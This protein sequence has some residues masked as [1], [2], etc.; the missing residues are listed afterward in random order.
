M[1][2]NNSATG[3]KKAKMSLGLIFLTVFID[4]VGFGLIIPILPTY[5]QQLHASDAMVGL[6]IAAYS[7]MQ[8]L[9]M[10]FWGRLSDKVG[11]KPILLISLTASVIGYVLWGFSYSLPMLFLARM[12]AGAGNANIAVAQA[13][14]ADVTTAENRTK[15]MALI[16][17][18]F[19]L[20]FVFGPAIGG[21]AAGLGLQT[22][23]F[24]AAGFSLVDL[25][26]TALIL[27]EPEKRSHAGE[28][29]FGNGNAFIMQTLKDKKLSTS[30]AI[31]FLSTFAFANMEAT[32]VLLTQQYFHFTPQQNSNLFVYVGVL[33]LLVQGGLVRRL[34]KKNIEKRMVSAGCFLTAIG[35]L[36]TPVFHSVVGLCVALA[37]LAVGSGINTPAN[38]SIL[39]KLSPPEKVGGVLGVGQSLSTLGRI[40]GPAVGAAAFG[41]LGAFCPYVIGAVAMVV[42]FLFSLKLPAPDK[43]AP[44]AQPVQTAV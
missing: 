34:A 42:A 13:Y 5:A 29:R 16:G 25:V 14:V 36:F 7:L 15:G 30:L 23:G 8:F 35:L 10:P 27:P 24:I 2:A 41:T 20:G 11:R 43:S 22:I 26:L 31:F 21:F 17:I 32:L 19:G 38:Q 6:V 44:T 37:F 39:S 4:L 9:F 12:V 3:D 1:A 40:L 28:E 18:A 33:I